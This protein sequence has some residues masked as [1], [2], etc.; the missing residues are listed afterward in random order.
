MSCSPDLL[1][2]HGCPK[3]VHPT[4]LESSVT[5]GGLGGVSK[6]LGAWQFLGWVAA[7]PGLA[8][9]PWE[10]AASL[11][12]SVFLCLCECSVPIVWRGGGDGCEHIMDD[13]RLVDHVSVLLEHLGGLK[14]PQWWG[15]WRHK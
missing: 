2:T 4:P 12:A 7:A 10:V 13:V 15:S 1:F 11:Y 8:V 5:V 3:L 14:S 9:G 6:Y